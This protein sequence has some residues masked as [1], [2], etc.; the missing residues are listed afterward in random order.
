[1]CRIQQTA[2]S[3]SMRRRF[4]RTHSGTER[5]EEDARIFLREEVGCGVTGSVVKAAIQWAGCEQHVVVKLMEKSISAFCSEAVAYNRLQNE[6]V[7]PLFYGDFVG[8]DAAGKQFGAI[9]LEALSHT[10]KHEDD[11]SEQQR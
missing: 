2:T 7:C 11:M 5:C 4:S 6:S 10:F 8:N 1:M 9:V 3:K